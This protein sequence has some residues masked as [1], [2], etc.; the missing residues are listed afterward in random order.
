ML[1]WLAILSNG[2]GGLLVAFI[3]KYADNI[4]RGFA[5]AIAIILGALGSYAFFGFELQVRR[6]VR[7]RGVLV[8]RHSPERTPPC[9]RRAPPPARARSTHPS[10]PA[11]PRPPFP[12]QLPFL[13]GV[14]LVIGAVFLYGGKHQTPCEIADAL[15][16]SCREKEATLLG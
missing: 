14:C 9:L 4:L 15:A 6:P 3:I 2:A 16:A 10:T 13:V 8:R 7:T 12:S 1:T 11:T 5:Q